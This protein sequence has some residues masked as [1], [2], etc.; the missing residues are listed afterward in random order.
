V[1]ERQGDQARAVAEVIAGQFP[2]LAPLEVSY[3]G[4]GYDSTAFEVNGTWV[5][6]FP[7][8]EDV[9]R[10]LLVER[11]LLPLLAQHSPIP[12]PEFRFHGVPSGQFK[13]HFAGYPKLAGEP[14]ILFQLNEVDFEPLGTA[15][16]EFLRYLHS[17]PIEIASQCGSPEW[18]PG[19]L[20]EEVRAEALSDVHVVREAAS[21]VNERALRG[22]LETG[23]GSARPSISRAVVHGDLAGEH[24]LIDPGTRRVSGIIDWSEI[25]VGDPAI[26]VA[27]MFHWGG[28][29]LAQAVL[30]H[31]DRKSD[32]E[33]L[34]RA[35]FF[36]AAR[37]VGDVI[38]GLERQR[39]EYIAAGVWAIGFCLDE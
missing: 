5:F 16:G 26:D 9:E 17:F 38:F 37:G 10:Q 35:R 14:G 12:I 33:L 24:I 1:A 39:P 19:E 31:Y 7:N 20:L 21:P 23:L 4:E 28:R 25:S 2:E 22:F 13:F 30:S 34:E 29:R 6:R 32:P 18:Q 8:R 11:A 15:L 36:A 27:G 3:L